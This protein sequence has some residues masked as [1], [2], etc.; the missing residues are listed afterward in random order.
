MG[1]AE[2]IS[3]SMTRGEM[4]KETATKTLAMM[5]NASIGTFQSETV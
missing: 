5:F 2:T 4:T 3:I 1:A